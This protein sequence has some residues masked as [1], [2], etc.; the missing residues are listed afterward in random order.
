MSVSARRKELAEL[1]PVIVDRERD[2]EAVH[3]SQI[4]AAV[5]RDHGHLVDTEVEPPPSN[6]VR[7]K[8]ELR[9]ELETLVAKG[10]VRRRKDLGPTLY[11][12]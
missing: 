5:E 11:S 7:W 12:R 10:T 3:L 9:W 4:Y 8:H 1:I 6:A 2:G